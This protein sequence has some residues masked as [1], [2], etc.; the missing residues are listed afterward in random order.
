MS[1]GVERFPTFGDGEHL[2]EVGGG[3]ARYR[4]RIPKLPPAALADFAQAQLRLDRMARK[5]PTA[6]PWEAWK[7][8]RLGRRRR[9][10]PGCAA[11]SE[12]AEGGR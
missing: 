9:S 2:I 5:V 12:R 3:S 6:A 4:G 10:G 1:S 7:A 8:E 11:T